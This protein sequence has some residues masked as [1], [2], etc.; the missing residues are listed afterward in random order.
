MSRGKYHQVG[1]T[2]GARSVT[3][4]RS[5]YIVGGLDHQFLGRHKLFQYRRHPIS[6]KPVG[7]FQ[8]PDEFDHNITAHIAR[9]FHRE[10]LQQ[11]ASSLCLLQVV[12]DQIADN[13]VGV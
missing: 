3:K 6:R 9:T 5:S 12:A 7:P 1:E 13:D 2:R 11:D 10:R 4:R 8:D